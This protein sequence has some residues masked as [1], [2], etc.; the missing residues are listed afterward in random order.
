[1][2]EV[3]DMT[4]RRKRVLLY[5]FTAAVSLTLGAGCAGAGKKKDKGSSEAKETVTKEEKDTTKDP[6]PT[7]EVPR[8]QSE[9]QYEKL[10]CEQKHEQ[11]EERTLMLAKLLSDGELEPEREKAFYQV[12]KTSAWRFALSSCVDDDESY[13]EDSKLTIEM[14]KELGQYF[15][16][17]ESKAYQCDKYEED[18]LVIIQQ[19]EQASDAEKIAII[20]SGNE[21]ARNAEDYAA[22]PWCHPEIR[23]AVAD[24]VTEYRKLTAKE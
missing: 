5:V 22:L 2:D 4:I 19:F 12:F 23:S 7:T 13:R 20:Q 17:D 10:T 24:V 8:E 18:F 16:R 1:M 21:R 15:E 6:A 14:Q 11:L 9:D 3:L